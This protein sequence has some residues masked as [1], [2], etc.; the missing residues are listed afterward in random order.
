M[1]PQFVSVNLGKRSV[2]LDL[3]DAESLGV[4]FRMLAEADVFLANFTQVCVW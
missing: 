1:E 2:A 4:V 3:K